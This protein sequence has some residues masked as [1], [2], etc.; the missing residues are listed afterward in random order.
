MK[1]RSILENANLPTTPYYQTW[2]KQYIQKSKGDNIDYGP[3]FEEMRE[4]LAKVPHKR[5]VFSPSPI[6]INKPFSNTRIQEATEKLGGTV[7]YSPTKMSPSKG[8]TKQKRT[9]IIPNIDFEDAK[10]ING[11]QIEREIFKAHKYETNKNLTFLKKN[12][13]SSK[14]LEKILMRNETNRFNGNKK[15]GFKRKMFQYSNNRESHHNEFSPPLVNNWR[16]PVSCKNV[17]EYHGRPSMN[18]LFKNMKNS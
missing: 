14:T 4:K 7:K 18:L 17:A 16:S 3:I 12:F 5:K 2:L 15:Q 11:K 1:L 10:P 6:D 9:S 8:E 13:L